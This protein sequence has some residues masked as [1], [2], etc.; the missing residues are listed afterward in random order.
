MVKRSLLSFW[1]VGV[2]Y[3][4]LVRRLHS[5]FFANSSTVYIEVYAAISRMDSYSWYMIHPVVNHVF[6]RRS[7]F[8]DGW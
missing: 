8:S 7:R 5:W 6:L 1:T 2:S 4:Y 3:L